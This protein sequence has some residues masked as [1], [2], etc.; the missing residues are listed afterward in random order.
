MKLR[1][2]ENSVRLRLTKGEVADFAEKGLVENQTVFGN[3]QIFKYR[4]RS[5]EIADKVEIRFEN[6]CIET[7][8]PKTIALKW[9]TSDEVSIVA[10]DHSIRIL[11]EKDFACLTNRENED[12]SDAFPH[13]KSD[14]IRC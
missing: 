3:S 12:E 4:L 1:I 2:R 13:P 10:D 9:A 11:I 7:N 8:V 14:N 5:S 6:G